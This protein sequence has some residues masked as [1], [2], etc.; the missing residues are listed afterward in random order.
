MNEPEESYIPPL[1]THIHT[2]PKKGKKAFQKKM[3]NN[4]NAGE[5]KRVILTNKRLS[6]FSLFFF[7]KLKWSQERVPGGTG[8]TIVTRQERT[9]SGKSRSLR[10]LGTGELLERTLDE[11]HLVLS[12]PSTPPSSLVHVVAGI[13]VLGPSL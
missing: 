11:A 12:Q 3:V 4:I 1:P 10:T 2:P 13:W 7:P 5:R 8:L 9:I 6:A